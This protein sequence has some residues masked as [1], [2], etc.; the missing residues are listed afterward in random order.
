MRAIP[1]LLCRLKALT[2]ER[3]QN[4]VWHKLNVPQ[5]SAACY[6]WVWPESLVPF[7]S[8]VG[9]LLL[10]PDAGLVALNPHLRPQSQPAEL[11]PASCLPLP[12]LASCQLPPGCLP[13]S[14][15][16]ADCSLCWSW[17]AR[18]DHH[19]LKTNTTTLQP[20]HWT[21]RLSCV[22]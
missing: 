5:A 17:H 20:P 11:R 2:E 16:Q 19:G 13:D 22:P 21:L 6:L 12:Y 1:R 8:G 18:P 3:A 15:G 10:A 7:A 14:S 9:F 4:G